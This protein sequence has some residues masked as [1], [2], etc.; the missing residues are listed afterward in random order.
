M[1]C[2]GQYCKP[3][4]PNVPGLKEYFKGN[5]IHSIEYDDPK[6]Y[7]GQ[8]V[9]CVGGRASGADLARE[10]SLEA[11]YVYL[12]DTTCPTMAQSPNEQRKLN[13]VEWVPTTLEVLQDGSIKFDDKDLA[14]AKDIDTIIFCTG[15]DYSFPFI[16][17]KTSNLDIDF[18]PGERRVKPLY[19]Q[20]LH[21]RYP[22]LAFVG[23][24]HSVVPFPCFELQVEATL[25]QWNLV[26][27]SGKES[28]DDPSFI[29]LAPLDERL[30]AAAR[31]AESGGAKGEKGR[32]Q[33][34]HYL[35]NAQWDYCRK[36]AKMAG[37]YDDSM[38][39]YLSMNK[40]CAETYEMRQ[41]TLPCLNVAFV[42][43]VYAP[44]SQHSSYR[45]LSLSLAIH[46]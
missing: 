45:P 11:D 26:K 46:T 31:D 12:S 43:A 2:N 1:I 33:D 30:Q 39:D 42:F 24:P 16:N 9:L 10:I 34:T 15:Y 27:D 25:R 32:I 8:N 6:L 19:E 14:P 44:V 3:S 7:K 23:L 37:N 21:A 20:L 13:N 17:P 29:P 38:E 4:I 41:V 35:G 28:T 18:L 36:M 5:I 40:V 22:N